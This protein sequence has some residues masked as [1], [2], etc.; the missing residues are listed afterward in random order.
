MKHTQ[1]T[2]ETKK[3]SSNRFALN[4]EG[5]AIGFVYFYEPAVSVKEA[6][7]NARL[8]AAAPELLE[9]CKESWELL[10]EVANMNIQPFPIRAVALNNQLRQALA[11]AESN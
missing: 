6:K 11:K 5:D 2:W 4:V 1:G 7:A 10:Q 8:I 3:E 9:A